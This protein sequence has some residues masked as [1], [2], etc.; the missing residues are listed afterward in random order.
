MKQLEERKIFRKV[1]EEEREATSGIGVINKWKK[2][3]Q[4]VEKGNATSGKVKITTS[5]SRK[6]L[7]VVD[8]IVGN[9][10]WQFM[11]LE[12]SM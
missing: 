4:Q 10:M 3:E 9:S 12:D 11:I 8:N 7:K 2:E 6:I 1:K 5:G